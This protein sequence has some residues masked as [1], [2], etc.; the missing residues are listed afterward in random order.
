MT[1]L[2]PLGLLGLLAIPVIIVIYI[3]QSKYTEQTVPSTYLWHLSDKYLKRRNPFSGITG[4]ISMLLQILTVT[5]VSLLI[6]HPILTLPGAAKD[7]C[8]IL[9]ASGSMNTAEDGVTRFEKGKEEIK[10][11][12]TE[13]KEGSSYTLIHASGDTVRIFDGLR[14]KET[15]LSLL[16]ETEPTDMAVS[17]NDLLGTAQ[18]AFDRNRSSLLYLVT[19]KNYKTHENI[20]IIDVGSDGMDNYAIFDVS[21]SHTGQQLRVSANVISYASDQTLKVQLYIDGTYA[22]STNV[23][24]KAGQM[25]PVTL[26]GECTEFASFRTEVVTSDAYSEDNAVIT[27]N[28]GSDRTYSTLIVSDSHFFLQT[29]IDAWSDSEIRVVTPDE[30]PTVKETFG[31]YIFDSYTPSALPNASVWLINVDE[32]LE[33]SGFSVRGR[34]DIISSELMQKSQSTASAV[35]ALLN[36]VCVKKET[37]GTVTEIYNPDIHVASSYIKYSGMYLRFSTL[38][39][40]DSSPVI[41]AGSNGLGHRQVVF[42]FD[43]HQSDLTLHADFVTLIGNLLHYSFPNVVEKTDHTVGDEATVNIVAGSTELRATSPSGEDIY[44]ESDG[45][46]AT[47]PLNEVGTYTVDVSISGQPATYRIYAGAHPDESAP[48]ETEADFSLTGEYEDANIDGTFDP[49]IL[50]FILLACLFIA[51]WGIYCYEKYQLR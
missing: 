13:A 44:L 30:Y 26:T 43:L 47:L 41:F 4:L 10:K 25:T 9:D 28:P 8:F 22:A 23:S 2:F 20:E 29:A 35:K 19:D 49:T 32:N 40:I 6:A 24:V 3:L 12:I 21:Y 14:D 15:A 17:H 31:L 5:V 7:Y 46:T 36:G 37:D 50:L 51:D 33:N 48:S 18:K 45:V 1:F 38:F 16:A 11:R 42:G 27:Y 39:S 34:K